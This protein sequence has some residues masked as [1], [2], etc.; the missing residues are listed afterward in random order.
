MST[1]TRALTKK[2]QAIAYLEAL[3]PGVEPDLAEMHKQ[4]GGNLDSMRR[5]VREWQAGSIEVPVET[6]SIERIL[7][8]PE[9]QMRPRLDEQKIIQYCGLVKDGSEGPP[10]DVFATPD[11][12]Y[13]LAHGHHRVYSVKMAGHGTIKA[14]IRKGDKRDALIF[15][16]GANG[17]NGLPRCKATERKSVF[18]LLADK[19]WGKKSD[20]EIGEYLMVPRR[21]INDWRREFEA[22]TETKTGRGHV[23]KRLPKDPEPPKE[24][25]GGPPNDYI[26]KTDTNGQATQDEDEEQSHTENAPPEPANKQRP[27]SVGKGKGVVQEDGKNKAQRIDEAEEEFLS[28]I[29]IREKLSGSRRVVMEKDALLYYRTGASRT[30]L[31]DELKTAARKDKI[32]LG[33]P[34]GLFRHKTEQYLKTTHPRE[35]L[36]CLPCK[37]QGCN[38]C[39][40]RGY[41]I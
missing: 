19:E 31:T 21:T 3:K 6:I 29:P 16:A 28:N 36:L 4:I 12:S 40:K 13:W 18:T 26:G 2:E 34:M 8:L 30:M 37:G 39:G 14:R 17:D 11:H 23:A 15:A 38:K 1:T 9:L 24:S 27:A 10:I 7:D 41:H 32:P 25:F 35:W 22:E 33:F 20:S 5:T